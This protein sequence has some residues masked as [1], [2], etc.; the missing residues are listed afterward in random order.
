M[1]PPFTTQPRWRLLI[2]YLFP[3]HS[4]SGR[5]VPLIISALNIHIYI[6]VAMFACLAVCSNLGVAA[7]VTRR[8]VPTGTWLRT[9]TRSD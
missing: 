5:I 1:L 4:L 2:G 8:D 9:V 6:S 7:D 3:C